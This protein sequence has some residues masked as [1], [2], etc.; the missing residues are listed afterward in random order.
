MHVIKLR[1]G[2]GVPRRNSTHADRS[3]DLKP[4]PPVLPAEVFP[5]NFIHLPGC[6][7]VSWTPLRAVSADACDGGWHPSCQSSVLTHLLRVS[8]AA[9]GGDL[10][11]RGRLALWPCPGCLHPRAQRRVPA[12]R[13][14]A[15]KGWPRHSQP[16]RDRIW[17]PQEWDSQGTTQAMRMGEGSWLLRM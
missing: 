4:P 12:H 16:R 15:A 1:E 17:G 8:V 5:L 10:L 2:T 13:H 9:D 6:G 7:L 14:P 11:C 3:W